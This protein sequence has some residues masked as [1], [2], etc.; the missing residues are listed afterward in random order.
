MSLFL[1]ELPEQVM[2]KLHQFALHRYGV[3]FVISRAEYLFS[4]HGSQRRKN[5]EGFI[6]S[7]G[8]VAYRSGMNTNALVKDIFFAKWYY[9]IRD[10]DYFHFG[11]D[12]SKGP[13]KLKYVGWQELKHYY[14]EL[15]DTGKADIFD[16]KEKTYEK[17]REFYHRE[18]LYI[19]AATEKEIFLDFFR[20]RGA[21]IIKPANAFGGNGVQ[22]YRIS[23][24]TQ[25]EQVWE[26]AAVCCPFVL[27]E[28]ITQ[29]PEMCVFYP[30]AINTIRYTTF[31]HEGMLTKLQATL[32]MGRGGSIVDNITQGGIFAPVDFETGRI[33][34]P[35]RSFLC[36]CFERHP[37]T[38]IQ[39]EGNYVPR[40]NELNDLV[41]KVVG[42]VPDKKLVG[43]DFALSE[44][45]WV[46]VEANRNPG[47]Q[48]F[49]PE[50]GIREVL[51]NT[52]G[53][54]VPMWD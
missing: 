53:K 21:G 47:L 1:S 25:L 54:V 39:L 33:K 6:E 36:E 3:S 45:G 17:Y 5:M 46:I 23:D 2:V 8:D 43:W 44:D 49:D 19:A 18:V 32:R 22:I 9:A 52:I 28:L 30:N 38:G 13:E 41:E 27:E 35:A 48:S 34:G 15:T 20:R 11:L 40:W 14:A 26:K 12:L 7:F 50:H 31:Y 51:A 4:P 24:Q 29:A 16:Q 42:V 37:D 10:K